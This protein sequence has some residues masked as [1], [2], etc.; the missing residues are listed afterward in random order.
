MGVVPAER[1]GCHDR[2]GCA[3]RRWGNDAQAT[4]GYARAAHAARGH[5]TDTAGAIAIAACQG[6]HGVLAARGQ[7]ITN[8][9]T[10][11]DEAGLREVDAILTGLTA[12]PGQLLAAIN[13]A[14][15]LVQAA[16]A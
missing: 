10:L 11:I 1:P 12:E 7:W 4:L 2:D 3:P 6:A 15:A 9:K 14:A 8:E 5:L 13:A 16:L